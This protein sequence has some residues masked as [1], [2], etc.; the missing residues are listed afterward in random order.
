M[1][2]IPKPRRVEEKDGFAALGRDTLI[3]GE[4]KNAQ[5]LL[6]E[7]LQDVDGGVGVKVEFVKDGNMQDSQYILE[8]KDNSVIIKASSEKG[9]FYALM[10]IKQI[11]CDKGL[12]CVSIDD[13]PNY[14]YRGFSLDCARHFWTVEKIKQFIDVM[15]RWS[16]TRAA[17]ARAH[18]TT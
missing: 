16:I 14:E 13:A 18:P 4:F 12:P 5:T 17:R 3:A 1:N 15:A 7:F 11:I 9:A 10:T 8:S 6:T 2:I